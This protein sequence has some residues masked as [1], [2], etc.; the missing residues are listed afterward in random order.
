MC[1]QEEKGGVA[2]WKA[3]L[4]LCFYDLTS[5]FRRCDRVL[6]P[7]FFAVTLGFS[8]RCAWY[9]FRHLKSELIWKKHRP[10]IFFCLSNSVSVCDAPR[11]KTSCCMTVAT[12]SCVTLEVLLT[13]SRTLKQKGWMR[14]RRRSRSKC[15]FPFQ[16]SCSLCLKGNFFLV[17]GIILLSLLQQIVC[18]AWQCLL[19]V[20]E[21]PGEGETINWAWCNC[22]GPGRLRLMQRGSPTSARQWPVLS[23]AESACLCPSSVLASLSSRQGW[24]NPILTELPSP[25]IQALT[26]AH[27]S[28]AWEMSRRCS[29]QLL[30]LPRTLPTVMAASLVPLGAF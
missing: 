16:L 6:K 22:F 11:L 30:L 15:P 20:N 2:G 9:V 21:C 5:I 24:H 19:Q 10:W 3:M 14:S 28:S 7:V 1:L 8:V 13:N 26:E 18:T 29:V 12:M 25:Q 27:P 4:Q 23:Y 17:L